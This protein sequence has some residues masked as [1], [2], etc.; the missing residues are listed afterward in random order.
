MTVLG[1]PESLL[2]KVADERTTI[3]D[4]M[5]NIY[6]IPYGFAYN[7]AKPNETTQYNPGTARATVPSMSASGRAR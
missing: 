5:K 2:E 3:E 4:Q 1:A 6:P 7:K